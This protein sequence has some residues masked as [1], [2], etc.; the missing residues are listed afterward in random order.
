[1]NKYR[2]DIEYMRNIPIEHLGVK[3][4]MSEIKKLYRVGLKGY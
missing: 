3:N 1:M 2:R 4:T